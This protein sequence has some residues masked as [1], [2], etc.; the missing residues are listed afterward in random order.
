LN[1]APINQLIDLKT[2]VLFFRAKFRDYYDMYFIIKHF[3]LK[4][5]FESFRTYRVINKAADTKVF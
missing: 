3:G 5:T 2:Q 4:E 1:I